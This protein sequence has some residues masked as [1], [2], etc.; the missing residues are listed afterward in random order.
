[1]TPEPEAETTVK[2]RS[3]GAIAIGESSKKIGESFQKF[4]ES[5]EEIET[6]E[7][8]TRNDSDPIAPDEA[9][10]MPDKIFS[11]FPRFEI[12]RAS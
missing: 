2:I 7:L 5:S 11:L 1:M 4:G 6:E 3:I 12:R 10:L 8:W 9:E